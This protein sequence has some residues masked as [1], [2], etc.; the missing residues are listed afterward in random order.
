MAEFLSD[1][2]LEDLGSQLRPVTL[3]ID[4]RVGV[5]VHRQDVTTE[6]QVRLGPDGTS[7]VR[8]AIEPAALTLILDE[9]AAAE[10]REQR[11]TPRDLLFEGRLKL[12]G[13]V[14]LL[15]EQTRPLEVLR[16]GTHPT[17]RSR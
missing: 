6:Y 16:D 2:W 14:G 10:L 8:D 11:A 5:V 4:L 3:D 15:L 9:E 13:D 17:M 12:R 7:V 1:A